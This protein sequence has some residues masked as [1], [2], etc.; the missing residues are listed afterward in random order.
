MTIKIPD[1]RVLFEKF[2]ENI[3]INIVLLTHLDGCELFV[4][5]NNPSCI[6]YVKNGKVHF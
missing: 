5:E 6:F 4:N 1:R 2:D 3:N